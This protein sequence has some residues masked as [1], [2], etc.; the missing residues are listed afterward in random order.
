MTTPGGQT[1]TT[2]LTNVSAFK[3]AVRHHTV[4]RTLEG[5]TAGLKTSEVRDEV[6]IGLQ[7]RICP[8]PGLMNEV[9]VTITTTAI[10]ETTQGKMNFIKTKISIGLTLILLEGI[11]FIAL[12]MGLMI[13]MLVLII[14]EIRIKESERTFLKLFVGNLDF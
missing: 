10:M 6:L 5:K 2:T 11:L 8:G 12:S 3:V 1:T 14:R 7:V 9:Q 13:E 4:A